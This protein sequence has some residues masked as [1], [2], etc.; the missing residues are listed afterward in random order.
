MKCSGM[1]GH[2]PQGPI[3]WTLVVVRI[4][5]RIQEFLKEFYTAVNC[6]SRTMMKQF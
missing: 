6:H 5:I 3:C 2:N 4:W 1:V